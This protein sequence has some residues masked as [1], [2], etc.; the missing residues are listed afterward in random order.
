MHRTYTTMEKVAAVSACRASGS[1]R[2]TARSL[3]VPYENVRRW[4]ALLESG[5]LYDGARRGRADKGDGMGDH[6]ENT[7]ELPDDPAELKRIILEQR[8]EIDLMR[9]VVDV[10]KKRPLRRPVDP[11]EQGEDDGGRRDAPDVFTELF[12]L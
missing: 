11:D 5:R 3:G 7:G 1:I 4:S 10:V 12:G 9:A 2:G 8:F 6:P